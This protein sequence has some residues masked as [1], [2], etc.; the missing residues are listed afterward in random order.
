MDRG[1]SRRTEMLGN[2]EAAAAAVGR[3]VLF[4]HLCSVLTRS[5]SLPPSLIPS[6]LPCSIPILVRCPSNR[7]DR[8]RRRL[9]SC[10]KNNRNPRPRRRKERRIDDEREEEE[11]EDKEHPC[12]TQVL[13]MSCPAP[14]GT[15]A[16]YIHTSFSEHIPQLEGYTHF[17]L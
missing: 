15:A 16:R 13:S 5:T 12:P 7:A 6:F 17:D 3:S 9:S 10:R 8:G 4:L 11:G 14:C 2:G 1:Q